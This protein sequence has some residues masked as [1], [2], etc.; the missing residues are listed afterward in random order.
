MDYR[1]YIAWAFLLGL[2][3]LLLLVALVIR[4]R[5]G[6]KSRSATAAGRTSAAS[7]SLVEMLDYYAPLGTTAVVEPEQGRV[8][9]VA[10]VLQDSVAI[11]Q[12]PQALPT[13]AEQPA[14]T[15]PAPSQVVVHSASVPTAPDASAESPAR[16][17]LA[18]VPVETPREDAE[19]VA[20]SA[21]ALEM[22]SPVEVWFE[23]VRV[24]VRAGTETHLRFLKCADV[25]L[26]D[27]KAARSDS[28]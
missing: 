18:P 23:G 17:L 6:S 26:D 21:P 13:A 8:T 7:R 11:E 24:G 2:A 4:A 22:S 16:Q 9:L 10:D 14:T 19:P 12:T 28:R 27:L 15:H 5:R 1:P 3:A 25:L 20:D